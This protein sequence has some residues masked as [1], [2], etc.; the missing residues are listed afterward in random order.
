MIRYLRKIF[1]NHVFMKLLDKKDIL[2]YEIHAGQIAGDISNP[3][4]QKLIGK[5]Y[6]WKTNRKYKN[7]E[8]SFRI[9]CVLERL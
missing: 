4:L 1:D 3:F 7:Y 9:R 2:E 8:R 6:A 5:Y